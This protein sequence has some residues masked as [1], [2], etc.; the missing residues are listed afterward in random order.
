LSYKNGK[1]VR[2]GMAMLGG[3]ETGFKLKK[4]TW[5]KKVMADFVI[6]LKMFLDFFDLSDH[7]FI[8]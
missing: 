4:F 2:N 5:P 8:S 6:H 7:I 1:G 3:A